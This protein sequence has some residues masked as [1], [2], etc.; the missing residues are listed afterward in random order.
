MEEPVS[1]MT[2]KFCGGE[3]MEIVP[4][5]SIYREG[6]EREYKRNG[7]K[8]LFVTVSQSTWTTVCPSLKRL[9]GHRMKGTEQ[10]P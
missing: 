2:V 5:Y 6:R 4:K 7:G 10:G 3:P 9:G 1:K 8:G